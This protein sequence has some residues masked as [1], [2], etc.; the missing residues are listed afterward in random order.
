MVH[1]WSLR[2]QDRPSES[3]YYSSWDHGRLPF[4]SVNEPHRATTP[5]RFSG[6]VGWPVSK[7]P[8]TL[9]PWGPLFARL[10]ALGAA[11]RKGVSGCLGLKKSC[12]G[13]HLLCSSPILSVDQWARWPGLATKGAQNKGQHGP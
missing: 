6:R 9:G 3:P 8:D 7:A 10:H 1:L 4:S 12:S 11:F 13:L 5:R 2:A